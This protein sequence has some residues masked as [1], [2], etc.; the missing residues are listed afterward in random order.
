MSSSTSPP[1]TGLLDQAGVADLPAALDL[2][3]DTLVDALAGVTRPYAG[4]TVEQA[5]RIVDGVDLDS[6]VGDLAAALAKLRATYLD[7]TVWVHH[8]RYQAHVNC[9]VALPAVVADVVA[10]VVNTSMDT[11]DQSGA[12]TLVEQRL[13]GWVGERTGF[14]PGAGGTFTSGGTQ[15]NLHGLLLAREAARAAGTDPRRWCVVVPEHAHSSV[16]RAAHLLGISP[17]TAAGGTA[18]GVVPVACDE[19]GRVRPDALDRA[20]QGARLRGLVPVAVVGT[21]GTTDLGAVDPLDAVADVAARHDTWLHVDAAYGGGLL[22]SPTRR[23]L[24][25]GIERA[26]SVTVDLH[27]TWFQPVAC[28]MLLVRRA[29]TLVRHHADYLNPAPAPGR[30]TTRRHPTS[31]TTACRRPVAST[32]SSPGSRC[33]CSGPTPWAG[34]STGSATWPKPCGRI[35]RPTPRS[36]S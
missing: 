17:T 12:A 10:S 15:S 13:V 9:P 33:A 32:P 29:P 22:L 4:T 24:L 18:D 14:G 7:H 20:L 19:Q 21:A 23:H 11:W 8:P 35:S 31:S 1:P 26:D 25:A 2:V 16:R 5:R 36:R 34:S 27:K 28:S 6:P 30:A 3:R